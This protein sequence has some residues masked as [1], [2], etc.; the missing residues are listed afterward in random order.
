MKVLLLIFGSRRN[1]RSFGPNCEIFRFR[2]VQPAAAANVS[3]PLIG[4]ARAML[5]PR[6]AVVCGHR[7]LFSARKSN[8]NTR[9]L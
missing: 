3:P 6:A 4:I 7:D 5:S 1:L 9:K 8:K 2:P